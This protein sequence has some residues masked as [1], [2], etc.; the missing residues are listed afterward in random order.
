LTSPFTSLEYA[1]SW[2]T[3]ALSN[4]LH[5]P[6][7]FKKNIWGG[8]KHFQGDSVG[9]LQERQQTFVIG[10]AAFEDD[11]GKERSPVEER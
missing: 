6:V 1:G 5:L 9:I 8:T 3:I 2:I 7:L 11:C 4:D 10:E